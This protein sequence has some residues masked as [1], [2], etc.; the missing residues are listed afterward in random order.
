MTQ[1]MKHLMNQMM[2]DVRNEMIDEGS[3]ESN[4]V[5][6]DD[7]DTYSCNGRGCMTFGDIEALNGIGVQN[8]LTLIC[9]IIVC[10]K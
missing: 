5:G 6:S 4:N 9:L 7:D 1:M 10:Q 2:E 8:V 3:D